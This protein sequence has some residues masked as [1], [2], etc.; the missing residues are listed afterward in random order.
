MSSDLLFF[1][2]FEGCVSDLHARQL[3]TDTGG[4]YPDHLYSNHIPSQ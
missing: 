4:A 2:G 3:F 1:T